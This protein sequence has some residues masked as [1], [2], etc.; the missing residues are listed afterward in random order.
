MG[1]DGKPVLAFI[2]LAVCGIHEDVVSDFAQ[3][4]A[5]SEGILIPIDS[6]QEALDL[7]E[8]NRRVDPDVISNFEGP[9]LVA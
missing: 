5:V 1:K 7:L 9:L 6:L 4:R 3:Q 2:M 8:V